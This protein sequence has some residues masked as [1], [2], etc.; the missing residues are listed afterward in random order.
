MKVGSWIQ[1]SPGNDK[2]GNPIPGEVFSIRKDNRRKRDGGTGVIWTCT[3]PRGL[4]VIPC[5]H[6]RLIYEGAKEGALPKQLKLTADGA[7]AAARCG[8][9]NKANERKFAASVATAPP[10]RH[11]RSWLNP[12]PAPAPKP[13]PVPKPHPRS[14][15]HGKKK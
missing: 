12:K 6:L 1:G 4:D 7:R 11:P 10:V 3:C 9:L 5:R 15:I 8:C 2:S 13:V 14:W